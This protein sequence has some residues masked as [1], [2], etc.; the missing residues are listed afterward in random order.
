MLVVGRGTCS[1]S[2]CERAEFARPPERVFTSLEE[3]VVNVPCA[4]AP[5]SLV[6]SALTE[7]RQR[8]DQGS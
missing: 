4:L 6:F 7:S 8:D 5:Q 2:A 3:A 1:V